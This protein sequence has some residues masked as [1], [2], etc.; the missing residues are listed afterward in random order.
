M[1]LF[2]Q[3][4]TSSSIA[5]LVIPVQSPMLDLRPCRRKF[6]SKLDLH[7]LQKVTRNLDMS[8]VGGMPLRRDIIVLE[9]ARRVKVMNKFSLLSEMLVDVLDLV[10]PQ[11]PL[12]I[13]IFVCAEPAPKRLQS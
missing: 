3:M 2:T 4:A 11:R 13:G 5:L 6:P 10:H 12:D 1:H 9:D 7:P 8:N